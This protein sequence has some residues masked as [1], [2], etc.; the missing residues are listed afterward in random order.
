[1]AKEDE[2]KVTCPECGYEV[3]TKEDGTKIKAHRVSGE[4]CD[5]SD[6]EVLSDDTATE[7]IDKGQSYEALESPQ[8]DEQATEDST[9]P[10]DENSAQTDAQSSDAGEESSAEEFTHEVRVRKPAPH[11]DQADVAWHDANVKM[12]AQRA[13]RAGI[14][15]TRE[16]RHAETEDAGTHFIVRYSAPVK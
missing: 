7:G 1:M 4:K 6:S 3:G 14:V 16:P 10:E 8:D 12:A 9:D 15:L 5:G 2:K 11:L 13:H